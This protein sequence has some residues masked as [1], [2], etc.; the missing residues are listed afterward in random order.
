VPGSIEELKSFISIVGRP[1]PLVRGSVIVNV[2]DTKKPNFV[3]KSYVLTGAL[4]EE[5]SQ[6]PEVVKVEGFAKIEVD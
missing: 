2:R 1:P 5:G 3:Q 6:D 4:L